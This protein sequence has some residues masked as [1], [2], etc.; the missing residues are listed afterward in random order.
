MAKLQLN[1]AGFEPRVVE[2][3]LGTNRL[4]RA[5]GSDVHLEH[6]TVSGLHCE[7]VLGCGQVSVRDCGSTNGTFVD[8][9]PIQQ[10]TLLPGQTLRVGDVELVVAD[11]E[12]PISIPKFQAPIAAPPVVLPNGL[13]TCRRHSAV[14]ATHRCQ[15]CRELL[16][17]DCLHRL[18]RRGGKLLCLCPLCSYPVEAIGGNN[19]KKKSLIQ[20]L[21]ETTKLFFNRAICKN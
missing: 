13:V 16:C 11:T 18:R 7:V 21:C 14:V 9:T 4:G 15:H 3:K 20:R 6:L 8:G 5:P 1:T 10:A 12:V 2:L 19:R 17:E